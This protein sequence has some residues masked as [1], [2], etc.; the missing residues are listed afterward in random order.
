MLDFDALDRWRPVY[1]AL[2]PFRVL[3]P[4][5]LGSLYAERPRPVWQDIV[6]SIAMASNPAIKKIVLAG[7][8][9]SGKTTELTRVAT[10]LAPRY[11]VVRLD[12]AG[13]HPDGA[14]TLPL[15]A[16]VGVAVAAAVQSWRGPNESEEATAGRLQPLWRALEPLG[17]AATTFHKA[18]VG[19]SLL[20]RI[21]P[22]P[23][24]QAVAIAIDAAAGTTGEVL[25]AYRDLEALAGLDSAGHE[26]PKA[27]ALVI[28]TNALLAE[29]SRLAGKPPVIVLDGLDKKAT[30]DQLF[31]ALAD[32]KLLVDLGA[33][34]VFSGPI[35]LRHDPRFSGQ[36]PGS[37]QPQ[38]LHNVPV[39]VHEGAGVIANEPGVAALV[40]VYHRRAA[41][42]GLPADLFDVGHLREL[43]R[44]SSGV[45]RDFLVLLT[46]AVDK[47]VE[48]G[49]QRVT[50]DDVV[51]AI[52]ERKQ[53]LQLHLD[54]GRIELLRQVLATERL[55]P[56]EQ[57][58]DLLYNNYIACYPN[59][60]LWYRPHETLVGF[61]AKH[62]A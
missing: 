46:H 40:D 1:R 34:V 45:V 26:E 22:D 15:V 38:P 32:V 43:A 18:L 59:D 5:E 17:V 57:A 55:P 60:D 49:R 41:G 28:E 52:R 8:R 47:V 12:V 39:L 11:A 33:A 48:D 53:S 51:H 24:S 20:A 61:V 3:S 30:L 62:R 10:A 42:A 44:H 37:F 35:H 23:T 50:D 31:L 54:L 56:G 16:L 13:A 14:G 58:S 19:A 6:R 21:A 27:R 4:E 7:P 2:D 36:L 9:G 29:L 25:G